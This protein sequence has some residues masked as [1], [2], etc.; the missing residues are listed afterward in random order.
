MH[1]EPQKYNSDYQTYQTA[2]GTHTSAKDP[3]NRNWG[4]T[5]QLL[6]PLREGLSCEGGLEGQWSLEVPLG[7]CWPPG[8]LKQWSSQ[9]GKSKLHP[10]DKERLPG[11]YLAVR[12][13]SYQVTKEPQRAKVQ[14]CTARAQMVVNGLGVWAQGASGARRGHMSSSREQDSGWDS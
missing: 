12:K 1:L 10:V 14:T 4:H 11:L 2:E 13:C 3:L 6:H 5:T 7:I 9:V 8:S